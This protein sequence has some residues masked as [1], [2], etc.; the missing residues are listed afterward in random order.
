MPG[1]IIIGAGPGIGLAV[2]RRFAREGGPIGVIARSRATVDAAMSAMAR[3]GV[4]GHGVT[5]DASN[6]PGLREALDELMGRGGIPD[7]LVYNAAMIQSDRLG[8]LSASQH[9]DA[10]AVNVVGAMSAAAHVLPQ[11]A[12]AGHGS[13]LITGGMPRPLPGV[14]S[15]SLGKAGVRALAELLHGQ[16]KPY[17]IQV[18]TVT[19]AGPVAPG[20]AFDPDDIAERYWRLHSQPMPAW[21]PAFLYSG[22]P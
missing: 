20:S 22:R 7:A 13:Y 21:I 15:L 12:E 17:G 1:A 18:V 19:I 8:Q 14:I 2:A 3:A 16:F 10:W 4:D 11:M 6:E 9:L 5:A